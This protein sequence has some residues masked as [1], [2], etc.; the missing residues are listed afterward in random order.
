VSG[1]AAGWSIQ[2]VAQMSGVTARTLRYYHE[3]GLLLPARVGANGF[4]YYDRLELLRLQEILLL[5]ELGLDL[6]QIGQVLAGER[7]RVEALSGHYQ[8]LVAERD[9]VDRL[10]RTVAATIE[11]LREGTAMAVEKMFEGFPFGPEVLDELE[12]QQIEQTGT[13]SPYYDQ[14]RAATADWSDADYR[15]FE[16]DS[17]QIER[18]LLEL[19]RAGVR[20]DDEAVFVVLDEDV[21]IQQRVLT[22]DA[23]TYV[24][25]GAAFVAT[26]QLRAHFDRQDPRLAEY[27]RDAMAAY[28]RTRME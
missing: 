1:S 24:K 26:P 5:R 6:T 11:S 14:V 12:S 3:I 9:R 2:Q 18:R 10:A 28:A 19:L 13:G 4:R 27:L 15:R 17:T 25:L 23:D 16:Q 7:D 8:R 20:C 21:A 22:L